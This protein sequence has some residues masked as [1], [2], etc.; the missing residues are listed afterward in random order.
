MPVFN[1]EAFLDS[2]IGCILSQSFTDFELILVNDGS[3]DR[4]AEI[5]DRY[6]ALDKRIRVIHKTNEGSGPTRNAGIIMATGNYLAF[7]DC[8]DRYDA[9][10]LKEAY[11][12]IE[13]YQADLVVWGIQVRYKNVSGNND[14]VEFLT[15]IIHEPLVAASLYGCASGS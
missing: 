15:R 1:A 8:D 13:Q 11:E 7:P 9:E 12:S 6:A 14:A 3:T 10:M 4:S 2:S 5:C